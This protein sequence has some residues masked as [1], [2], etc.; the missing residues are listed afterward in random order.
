MDCVSAN[1]THGTSFSKCDPRIP[2][3]HVQFRQPRQTYRWICPKKGNIQ[4]NEDRHRGFMSDWVVSQCH[5]VVGTEGFSVN[6]HW[7]QSGQLTL[8]PEPRRSTLSFAELPRRFQACS[9]RCLFLA[10]LI[11]ATLAD[12]AR[13]KQLLTFHPRLQSSGER[14]TQGRE[15]G[16]DQGEAQKDPPPP[17]GCVS[18]AP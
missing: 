2:T 10:C 14:S 17:F 9:T 12:R 7:S 11:S 1:R 8:V 6:A 3:S 4:R 15:I 13:P 16:R 18:G 5:A